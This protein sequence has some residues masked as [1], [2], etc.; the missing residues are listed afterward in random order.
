MAPYIVKEKRRIRQHENKIR[1]E[2]SP[3]TVESHCG[4]SVTEERLGNG[5]AVRPVSPNSPVEIKANQY[6]REV[7][8]KVVDRSIDIPARDLQSGYTVTEDRLGNGFAVSPVSP[9]VAPHPITM[10][11]RKR[12]E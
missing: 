7:N 5:F 11:K 4:Y 8:I 12:F 10:N 3:N 6:V 2:Q 1:R 9:T